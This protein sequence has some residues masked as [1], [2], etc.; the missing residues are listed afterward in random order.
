LQAGFLDSQE[1]MLSREIK[2]RLTAEEREA[3]QLWDTI[4]GVD[5]TTAWVLVAEMGTHRE[6][7]PDARHLAKKLGFRLQR[8]PA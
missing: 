8:I 5:Q 4:P 2:R 1:R 7:F 6:Q 3:V